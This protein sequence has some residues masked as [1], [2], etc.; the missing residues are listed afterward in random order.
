MTLPSPPPHNIVESSEM[1][2][3]ASRESI[4]AKGVFMF[5]DNSYG[6]HCLGYPVLH[7]LVSAGPSPLPPESCTLWLPCVYL[8]EE[9][10]NRPLIKVKLRHQGHS[11]AVVR[12]AARGLLWR[13]THW[14]LRQWDACFIPMVVYCLYSFT[15]NNPEISSIDYSL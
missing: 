6:P 1:F 4:P 11:G 12:S 15:Q 5:Q 2:I 7:G 10:T 3:P 14:L 9:G 8:P 13:R